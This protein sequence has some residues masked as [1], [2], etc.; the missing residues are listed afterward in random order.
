MLPRPIQM[1]R[2]RT[3]LAGPL[4]AEARPKTNRNHN[5]DRQ[6][7]RKRTS[8]PWKRVSAGDLIIALP[9]CWALGSWAPQRRASFYKSLF[10]IAH[11]SRDRAETPRQLFNTCWQLGRWKRN[12]GPLHYTLQYWTE[13]YWSVLSAG[14]IDPQSIQTLGQKS[15]IALYHAQPLQRHC[16]GRK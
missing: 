4:I 9:R 3:P 11:Y 16:W 15:I 5:R 8:S 14:Q 13:M 2:L 1:A 12:H 10:G 6:T 7:W